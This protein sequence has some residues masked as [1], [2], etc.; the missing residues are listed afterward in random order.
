MS[1]QSVIKFAVVGHGHIG[2]RHIE[3]ITKNPNAKLVAVC[4]VNSSMFTGDNVNG[5]K[6]FDS[7]DSLLKSGLEFDVACIATPNNLHAPQALAAIE[8]RKHVVVE[9][10][11]ALTRADCEKIIYKALQSYRHVFCIMQNRYSPPAVWIKSLVDQGILGRLFMVQ[12]NC[13]WNR[14][15]RYYKSGDWKGTKDYDGGILFTQFSHFIDTIYWLFGDITDI[16]AR[17]WDFNHQHS[18][19]FEDSGFVSFNFMQ[20]GM[21]TINYTT[22]AWDKNMESSITIIAE[23]GSVKIGGQYLDQVEYCHVR[24]YSRPEILP[25]YNSGLNGKLNG[26][27]PN[28]MYVFE[29][30]VDVL[31][32]R[33]SIST[34]ALEG[35][36][37]VDIIERIYSH[38]KV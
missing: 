13:F 34:N 5:I 16:Q 6:Y 36:K 31:Q 24:N 2:K 9:K 10:P 30:V 25:V 8:A 22:S 32:G 23:N 18:T 12:I 33:N 15:D 28:H 3:M 27:T 4:D 26:K 21:G 1:Q 35:L 37:V 38:R 29:N 14:D 17:F 19:E 7:L 11:M 20:G